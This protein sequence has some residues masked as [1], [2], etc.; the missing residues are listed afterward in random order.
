MGP[1]LDSQDSL[2]EHDMADCAVDVL[3]HWLPRGNHEPVLELHGLG[4]LGPQLPRDDDLTPLGPTLHDEP[5]DTVAGSAG[6]AADEG[7]AASRGHPIAQNSQQERLLS[8]SQSA[9]RTF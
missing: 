5:Q 4:T 6:R 9:A 3:P 8:H 2:S 7:L 1:C